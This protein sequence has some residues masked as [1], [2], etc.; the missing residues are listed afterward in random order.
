MQAKAEMRQALKMRLKPREQDEARRASE[1]ALNRVLKQHLPQHSGIWLSY[2]GFSSEPRLL[3][4]AD[5]VS[6][7]YPVIEANGEMHFYSPTNEAGIFARG[8]FGIQ[9]PDIKMASKSWLPIDAGGD[10][11]VVG[12]LVPGLAFTR[13]GHRL[14]RGRG[15]YDRFLQKA[16]SRRKASG[17]KP[18][19][20]IGIGFHEQV[21]EEL[22][23]ETH[24]VVL[25][26]VL[27]DR[28]WISPV[29]GEEK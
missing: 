8:D 2:R 15:F 29:K 1:I 14:G 22:P 4:Q 20:K 28:E 7:A 18:L 26:A 27:T 3:D 13:A 16:I 6:F 5:S 17:L 23:C 10:A 21:V 12:A 19:I 9:T 11:K 24:D 25:D